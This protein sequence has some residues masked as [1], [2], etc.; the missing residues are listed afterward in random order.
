[1]PDIA[2]SWPGC[3]LGHEDLCTCCSSGSQFPRPGG[4]CTSKRVPGSSRGTVP[5]KPESTVPVGGPWPGVPSC[6]ERNRA[7]RGNAPETRCLRTQRSLH[8][9]IPFPEGSSGAQTEGRREMGGGKRGECQGQADLVQ[10]S[11]SWNVFPKGQQNTKPQ[12]KPGVQSF[13]PEK[14]FP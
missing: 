1:M 7:R 2:E 12:L 13:P 9:E 5:T 11:D 10:V 4:S 3:P 8:P 14:T 6:K